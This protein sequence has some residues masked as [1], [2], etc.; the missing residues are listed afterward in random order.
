MELRRWEGID[1][2]VERR[3][4]AVVEMAA[5]LSIDRREVF[6]RVEMR[7]AVTEAAAEFDAEFEYHM[8]ENARAG[9]EWALERLSQ[10]SGML[11]PTG[12]LKST[13][14]RSSLAAMQR[15]RAIRDSLCEPIGAETGGHLIVVVPAAEAFWLCETITNYEKAAP[16]GKSYDQVSGLGVGRNPSAK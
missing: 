2:A 4:M 11:K 14:S 5:A 16:D 1:D 13:N 9:W 7:D 3:L 6:L 15:L 8:A 12:A 10:F